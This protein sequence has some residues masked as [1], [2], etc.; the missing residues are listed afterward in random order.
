MLDFCD[1]QCIHIEYLIDKIKCKKLYKGIVNCTFIT[2][3]TQQRQHNNNN[4][5]TSESV[6][7]H[8]QRKKK[9][10]IILLL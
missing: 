3:I 5:D 8:I 10:L 7:N 2:W 4:N 1:M 6:I 9:T